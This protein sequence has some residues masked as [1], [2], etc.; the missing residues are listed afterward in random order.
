MEKECATH[1]FLH[2]RLIYIYTMKNMLSLKVPAPPATK[3]EFVHLNHA[4]Y[5][6]KHCILLEIKTSGDSG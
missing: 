3:I 6:L 5:T 1:L 4:F 2:I